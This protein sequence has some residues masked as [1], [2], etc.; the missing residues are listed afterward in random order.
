MRPSFTETYMSGERGKI[1]ITAAGEY[2]QTILD[3]GF[4]FMV[5]LF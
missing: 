5:C 2:R 1:P 3:Y 4:V